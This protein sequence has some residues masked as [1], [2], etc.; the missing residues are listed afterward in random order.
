LPLL[1]KAKRYAEDECLK[2]SATLVLE[3]PR[4]AKFLH[5]FPE[6]ENKQNLN[7]PQR[8]RTVKAV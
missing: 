7:Y 4:L 3:F 2:Y 6:E 1:D 8:K 5:W